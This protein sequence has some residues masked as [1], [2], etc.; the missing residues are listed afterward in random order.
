MFGF[1]Q[2]SQAVEPPNPN[3][4]PEDPK[5]RDKPPVHHF[6]VV[7]VPFFSLTPERIHLLAEI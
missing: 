5:L 3:H 7:L 6:A 4:N 1:L 2:R